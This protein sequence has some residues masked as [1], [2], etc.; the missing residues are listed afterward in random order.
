[1]QFLATSGWGPLLVVLCGP[2]PLLAEGRP[3]CDCLPLLAGAR[4]PRRWWWPVSVGLG[5]GFPVLRVF[6]ARC[7]CVVPVLLCVLCVCG[8]CVGGGVG[9]V[10]WVCLPSVLV[11]VCV[12]V[13][14]VS[15][16][17]EFLSSSLSA[18]AC[19]WCLCGCGRCVLWLVPRQSWLRVQSAIP[20]HSWLGSVGGGGVWSLATPS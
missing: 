18:R 12:C 10:V 2:S 19:C 3:G 20:R 11:C 5:G 15:V 16:V 6:L 4:W 1:M 17:C 13:C 8:V 9:G 14:G 7:V